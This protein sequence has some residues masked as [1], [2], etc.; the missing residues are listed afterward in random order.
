[1]THHDHSAL[2]VG[3]HLFEQIE[4]FKVEIVCRLV[5][6]QNVGRQ[7]QRAGQRQ[8]V[9]LPARKLAHRSARLFGGKQEFLH[10]ADDVLGLAIDGER[11][12]PPAGQHILERGFGIERG[13]ALIEHRQLQPRPQPDRAR[14][15]LQF[16]RQHADERRLARP[17]RSHDPHAA[18]A[19]DPGREIVDHHP[20]AESLGNPL[21]LDHQRARGPPLGHR[22][23]HS[24]LR[25]AII[26]HLLAQPR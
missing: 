5:Q 4:R 19:H 22:H 9:A 12:A 18:P 11:I 15:G 13:P 10:I 20:V 26:A 3:D 1:M 25:P 17:V 14:I 8:P 2:I 16:S 24:S 21:G 6:H 23:L 7:R